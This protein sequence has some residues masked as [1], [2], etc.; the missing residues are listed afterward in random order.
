MAAI[1]AARLGAQVTL[2]EKGNRLGRKLLISGGGRCNVTNAR[3]IDHIIENIPG[4]GKFLHS[5]LHQWSNQDIIQFFR[6]LGVELKEEDRG[7]MFPVTNRASTVLDAL[8][9][10]LHTQGVRIV[11]EASVQAISYRSQTCDFEI[12]MQGGGTF[13][14]DS[15]VIAVGGCSVPETGSTGDGYHFARTFSHTIVEPYPTS[16]ALVMHDPV[17]QNKTLQG[18]SLRQAVL[19]LYDRKKRLLTTEEGDVLFTHFGLSGPA[20]LRVSQYAVRSWMKDGKEPL[21]LTIDAD[22]TNTAMELKEKIFA[23]CEM[24]PKR[25]FRTVVKEVTAVSLSN[26]ILE[27]CNLP[28]DRLAAQVSKRDIE[29][30]VRCLKEIELHVADTLGLS[31]A[32]VTGGGIAIKEIDPRTM[33]SRKQRGLFFAGE[34]M[35]VHAHTGGYNITVAFSTGYV[36]G[37]HA[38]LHSA[39]MREQC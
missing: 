23:L 10:E 17:I 3:G 12:F 9:Q 20:A 4:N 39:L 27:S 16:V 8:L 38:A 2:L 34:V 21:L 18:V 29:Q 22:P 14:G 37:K 31:R 25:V 24:M 5:V 32:T 35:D 7:R 26:F 19:R 30:F 33:E 1:S 15:V 36:A 6:D 13:T 28:G 11:F